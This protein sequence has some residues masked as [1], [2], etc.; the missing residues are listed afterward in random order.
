[1]ETTF[2]GQTSETGQILQKKKFSHNGTHTAKI[3]FSDIWKHYRLKL[4]QKKPFSIKSDH[5]RKKL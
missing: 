4:T 3:S 1:M 2:I 5:L